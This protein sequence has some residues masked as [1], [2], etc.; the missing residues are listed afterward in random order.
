MKET[1]MNFEATFRSSNDEDKSDYPLL[2]IIDRSEKLIQIRE[3]NKDEVLL[4]YQLVD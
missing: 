4:P 2:T 1:K 3:H